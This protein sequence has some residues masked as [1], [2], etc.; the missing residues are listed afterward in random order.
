MLKYPVNKWYHNKLIE[1]S[2]YHVQML[3]GGDT[4]SVT[5]SQQEEEIMDHV[6]VWAEV[7][8]Y[9]VL[10]QAHTLNLTLKIRIQMYGIVLI[11]K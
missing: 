5:D 4:D 6:C 9:M 8:L 1:N 7:Q 11:L 2:S 3:V 10:H